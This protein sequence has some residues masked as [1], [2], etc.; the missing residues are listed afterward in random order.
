MKN[1]Q[2]HFHDGKKGSAM[3]VH[4]VTGMERGRIASFTKDGTL[5]IELAGQPDDESLNEKLIA[6]LGTSLKIP[7]GKIEIVAGAN[8]RY[9]LISIMDL[10]PILLQEKITGLVR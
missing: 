2:F 8:S 5:I 3:L 4:I 9:K 10:D 6:I 7:A 1:K